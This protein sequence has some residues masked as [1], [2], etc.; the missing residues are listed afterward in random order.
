MSYD[1]EAASLAAENMALRGELERL[2]S[3]LQLIAT[4][5]RP[6][7]SWNRDREACRV[8]AEEAL[9]WMK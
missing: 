1:Q 9:R 8:L 7:G 5:Q 3:A 4:P 6:D 2:R